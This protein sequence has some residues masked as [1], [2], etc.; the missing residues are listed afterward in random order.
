MCKKNNIA[1]DDRGISIV[2]ACLAL[3]V[4]FIVGSIIITYGYSNYNRAVKNKAIDDVQDAV[5]IVADSLHDDCVK[6]ALTPQVLP[7]P[8][9]MSSISTASALLGKAINSSSTGTPWT[10]DVSV[11]TDNVNKDVKVTCE[12]TDVGEFGEVYS[13]K[14]SDIN[15]T[16]TAQFTVEVSLGNSLSGT[17]VIRTLVKD[18]ISTV[19][20]VVR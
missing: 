17:T 15:G 6:E 14:V 4:L 18:S 10:Y 8:Q 1:K 7:E 9:S 19:N 3:L 11:S 2:F 5:M 16:A 20:K 12:R 13:F